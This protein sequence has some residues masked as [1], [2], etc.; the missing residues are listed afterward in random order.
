MAYKDKTKQMVTVDGNIIQ[1]SIYEESS[2]PKHSLGARATDCYG[3]VFRYCSNGTVALTAGKMIQSRAA[4]LTKANIATSASTVAAA[5]N[6]GGYLGCK[7]VEVS[8]PG[9]VKNQYQ[10][11]LLNVINSIT[12]KPYVYGIESNCST[13]PSAIGTVTGSG[14]IRIQLDR[15]IE[16]AITNGYDCDVMPSP[17]AAC[18]VTPATLPTGMV[19]GVPLLNVT[20][21]TSTTTY[22]FWAQTWGPAAV[23]FAG[24]A[25]PVPA[26]GVGGPLV[27]CSN[28]PG[29][30]RAISSIAAGHVAAA[31]HPVYARTLRVLVSV[32]PLL[33]CRQVVLTCL[34]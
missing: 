30:L 14:Y 2:S 16:E 1:Q 19:I 31:L 8:A 33:G 3:R 10:G 28:V 23:F 27:L 12:T 25:G 13:D 32:A 7:Y 20:A 29:A 9:V 21:S 22:Y 4:V 6:A 26:T 24:A 17:F 34:P 15:A 11:G 18:V 5:S